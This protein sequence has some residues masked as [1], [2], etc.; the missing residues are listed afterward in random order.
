[1]GTKPS[2]KVLAAVTTWTM[3]DA[4][5]MLEMDHALEDPIDLGGPT[6]IQATGQLQGGRQL[7]LGPTGILRGPHGIPLRL[8]PTTGDLLLPGDQAQE[9]GQNLQDPGLDQDADHQSC[10]V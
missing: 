2:A 10:Q 4:G 7:P 9:L 5:P 6:W 1:M 3:E 8:A